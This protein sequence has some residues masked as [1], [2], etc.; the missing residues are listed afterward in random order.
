MKCCKKCWWWQYSFD[1]IHNY[2]CKLNPSDRFD[3]L[4]FHGW[5]CK[6]FLSEEKALKKIKEDKEAANGGR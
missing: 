5:F 1:N 2:K 3:N 6:N 4:N